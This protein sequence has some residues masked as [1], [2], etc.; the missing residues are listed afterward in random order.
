MDGQ[1]QTQRDRAEAAKIFRRL[2]YC[3]ELFTVGVFGAFLLTKIFNETGIL[4]LNGTLLVLTVIY[5]VAITVRYFVRRRKVWGPHVKAAYKGLNIGFS[6]VAVAITVYS[7]ITAVSQPSALEVI[8]AALNTIV[9]IV[10]ILV[11]AIVATVQAKFGEKKSAN[12]KK[13]IK[14]ERAELNGEAS[15]D[16][17]TEKVS[18]PAEE[19]QEKETDSPQEEGKKKGFFGWL[20]GKIPNDKK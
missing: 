10:K 13:E 3:R 14:T 18:S 16:Q 7:I 2:D 8:L 20:F 4:V 19:V 5:T 11:T 15:E 17:P 12:E 1:E 6:L 9:L